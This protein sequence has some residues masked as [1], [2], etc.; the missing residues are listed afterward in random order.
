MT[1]IRRLLAAG[2]FVALLASGWSFAAGNTD[3]VAI[4]YL[5]GQTEPLPLWLVIGGACTLGIALSALYLGLSLLK[6]RVEIRRLRRAIHGLESEL[7]DFR[8]KPI[9]GD[10]VAGP[11]G[12]ET[13]PAPLRTAPGGGR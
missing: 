7:R 5:V 12:D 8:N 4:D 9:E 1:V 3:V 6:D 10:L 11:M 13:Q 2:L